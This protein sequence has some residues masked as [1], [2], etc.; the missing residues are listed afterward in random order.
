MSRCLPVSG[1]RLAAVRSR[2][3]RSRSPADR[4]YLPSPPR[5]ARPQRPPEAG[6]FR[7][8]TAEQM[9]GGSEGGR[10]HPAYPG[11]PPVPAARGVP[12]AGC[13]GPAARRVVLR[14]AFFAVYRAASA[15]VSRSLR[16]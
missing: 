11:N 12:G 14:P 10:E 8:E 4:S 1:P 5:P 2:S 9:S 15:A 13:S 7:A 3:T 6:Q 16:S